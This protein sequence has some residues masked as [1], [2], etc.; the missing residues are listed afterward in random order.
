MRQIKKGSTDRGVYIYIFDSTTGAPETGV[1]FETSGIDLWYRRQGGAKVSITEATLAAVDSAHSDGGIIHIADGEYRLDL[2]DAAF[3]TGA[4]DVKVGGTI[5]GMIVIGE[6]VQL[7]DFD[8]EDTVRLGL[9]ALPNAAAN[10]AGGLPVSAAGSLALDTKLAN[11]NEVT[12]ARMGALTDWIDGG[13]L[14]LLVDAVLARLPAALTGDGNIKADALKINSATPS[15]LGEQADAVWDEASTGHTDA[16]KAG[17]QLWTQMDAIEGQT[18]DIGAAGAGLSAVP[19][20]AAWDAEVESEVDD[21]IG[22]GTGTALTGIP[23]NAAWDAEVQSEVDDALKALAVDGSV[24][25]P[26]AMKSILA[27][28]CGSIAKELGAHAYKDQAGTGTVFTLTIDTEA[29]TV[30]RS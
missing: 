16:G 6:T 3:A 26:A 11:T 20:N 15:T 18:D 25:L 7:V 30:T 8:P 12:A 2:P 21:A 27:K 13:R 4:Q 9:T 10:A 5:T 17:A 28:A 1:T 14:D 24:M 19:W 22:G 29:G 23:W